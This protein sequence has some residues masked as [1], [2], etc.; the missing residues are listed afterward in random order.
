MEYLK[1]TYQNQLNLLN[2]LLLNKIL[3]KFMS[4]SAKAIKLRLCC[5]LHIMT[6]CMKMIGNKE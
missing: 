1:F 3:K 2:P 6:L 5:L 4:K